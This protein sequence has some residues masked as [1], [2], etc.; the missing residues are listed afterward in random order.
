MDVKNGIRKIVEECTIFDVLLV[1]VAVSLLC[2]ASPYVLRQFDGLNR[3]GDIFWNF[4]WDVMV[5]SVGMIVLLFL[6]KLLRV[7]SLWVKRN[8]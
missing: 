2:V 3:F 8:S 7:F 1:I 6:G 5:F 4:S